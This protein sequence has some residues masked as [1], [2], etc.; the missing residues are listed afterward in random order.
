MMRVESQNK[1]RSKKTIFIEFRILNIPNIS[2]AASFPEQ[3]PSSRPENGGQR[4]RYC[5]VLAIIFSGK[6]CK[7][8][9]LFSPP[10][11]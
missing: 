6:L 4:S 8:P 2:K 9:N 11:C 10:H 3:I 1:N 5:L 7:S